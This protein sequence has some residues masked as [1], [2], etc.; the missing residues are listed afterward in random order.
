MRLLIK[1]RG[2]QSKKNKQ[3]AQS[4]PNGRSTLGSNL[5]NNLEAISYSVNTCNRYP[6][7]RECEKCSKNH[8]TLAYLY[9]IFGPF[10]AKRSPGG[11]PRFD[12]KVGGRLPEIVIENYRFYPRASQGHSSSPKAR[13]TTSPTDLQ[14]PSNGSRPP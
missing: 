1:N 3:R 12:Q 8:E 14:N 10:F 5:Y 11:K 2:P 13:Q 7:R 6:I 9:G 4:S